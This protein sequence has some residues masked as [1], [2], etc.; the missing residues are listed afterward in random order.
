MLNWE[1]PHWYTPGIPWRGLPPG[2]SSS[3]PRYEFELWY[4]Y[5]SCAAP[6]CG[7]TGSP[8]S[9]DMGWPLTCVNVGLRATWAALGPH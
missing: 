8:C 9:S 3:C 7:V 1:A 5:R 2:L 4:L 6:W